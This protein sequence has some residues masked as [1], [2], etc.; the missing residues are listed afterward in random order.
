MDV[1]LVFGI[2]WIIYA[3]NDSQHVPIQ[4]YES[5]LKLER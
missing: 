2:H 5:Y 1:A 3:Y 4:S